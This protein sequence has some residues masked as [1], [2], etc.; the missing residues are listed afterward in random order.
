MGGARCARWLGL[1]AT[2]RPGAAGSLIKRARLGRGAHELCGPPPS[3]STHWGQ[4]GTLR[5]EQ[6]AAG[7]VG[8]D[9]NFQ[10]AVCPR[11]MTGQ[12]RGL[13]HGLGMALYLSR[14]PAALGGSV[15][16]HWAR[17]GLWL[18]HCHVCLASLASVSPCA[19]RP[20]ACQPGPDL[21]PDGQKGWE[22]QEGRRAT[23]T[24]EHPGCSQLST[25]SPSGCSAGLPSGEHV[26]W[27]PWAVPPRSLAPSPLPGCTDSPPREAR[28]LIH[29]HT[30][31]VPAQ[32]PS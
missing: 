9:W 27:Y 26:P 8:P 18:Q 21:D 20:R 28:P 3:R 11:V 7:Q 29:M 30:G 13:P 5:R 1:G 16:C 32:G 2:W 14:C 24:H 6:A 10:A 12:L 23:Q 25:V 15:R 4:S 17:T 19:L 31:A 22:L